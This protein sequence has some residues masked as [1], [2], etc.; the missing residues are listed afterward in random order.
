MCASEEEGQSPQFLLKE[1]SGER[2]SAFRGRP[3]LRGDG[4]KAVSDFSLSS[5]SRALALLRRRCDEKGHF[6]HGRRAA[7]EDKR[8]QRLY[9][10]QSQKACAE[11]DAGEALCPTLVETKPSAASSKGLPL[12]PPFCEGPSKA[13]PEPHEKTNVDESTPQ[14]D[15]GC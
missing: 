3:W 13:G 2:G 15:G 6:E 8:L 14:R 9:Q 7:A 10:V 1:T 4:E 11:R 12:K 5:Q